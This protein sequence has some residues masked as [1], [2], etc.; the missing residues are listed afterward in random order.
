MQVAATA[1]VSMALGACILKTDIVGVAFN[2]GALNSTGDPFRVPSDLASS[3][4][5]RIVEQELADGYFNQGQGGAVGSWLSNA[6]ADVTHFVEVVK[7]IND[8]SQDEASVKAINRGQEARDKLRTV[9]TSWAGRRDPI[10]K[11]RPSAASSAGPGAPSGGVLDPAALE[12][13]L[14]EVRF[15]QAMSRAAKRVAA[16]TLEGLA[17]EDTVRAGA[18]EA[19]RKTAAYMNNRKWKRREARKTAGLAVEGG[20]ATGIFSAGAVWV[21]LHLIDGWMSEP[22][23]PGD[24]RCLET[25]D[26]AFR[27]ISGTSTGA[28]VAVAVDRFNSASSHDGRVDEMK[29]IA[30]WFTCFSFTDLMCGQSTG[31]QNLL[32]TGPGELQGVLEFDG[33]QKLLTSCV[34]PWMFT[35]PSELI[36]NTTEFRSGRIFALSDQNELTTVDQVVQAA[37]AS[38]LLPVI[39]DTGKNVPGNQRPF[40]VPYDSAN[41]D[42]TQP[43]YLDGGIR[44]ELPILPL[45]RRGA[46]RILAVASGASMIQETARLPNALDIFTRY[47]NV[48]TGAV[49][50]TELEY[51]QRIAESE[52]LAEIDAC[53]GTLDPGPATE[54]ATPAQ[55]EARRICDSAPKPG[56]TNPFCNRW[57][58]CHGKFDQACDYMETK[59]YVAKRAEEDNETLARRL[60]PFWKMEEIFVD[61]DNV[62]GLNGYDFRPSELRRLFRAGAEAARVRCLDIATLLGILPEDKPASAA[63]L[64]DVNRWCAVSLDGTSQTCDP[65]PT[66]SG[67]FSLRACGNPVDLSKLPKYLDACPSNA[68]P[69]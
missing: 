16:L 37:L 54:A 39:G 33:I 65:V 51:S 56:S 59:E 61:Q 66:T 12:L 29:N 10:C 48:N 69:K 42:R 36:L 55:E 8:P 26:I 52:R 41:P 60:E 15:K 63:Q 17:T 32:A 57:N 25:K 18:A 27:L 62:D 23:A 47:V 30:K 13:F 5:E 11:P 40:D 2:G 44:S 68:V 3:R 50:E 24:A 46:E 21:V 22:C 14:D 1:V 53:M 64:A 19:F 28:M 6:Q 45:V 7:S 43:A 4:V 31:I 35:N 9:A 38:A 34:K 58:I 20:A 49:T 67:D